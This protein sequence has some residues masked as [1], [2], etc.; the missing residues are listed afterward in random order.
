LNPTHRFPQRT[1]AL[2]IVLA[3]SITTVAWLVMRR[4]SPT[5]DP[6]G[7]G[8]DSFRPPG[9]SDRPHMELT[10]DHR[11]ARVQHKDADGLSPLEL[12]HTPQ[13]VITIRRTFS[14]A[15]ALLKEEASLNGQPVP[16]PRR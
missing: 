1:L 10:A 6:P 7:A 9:E 12:V 5:I 3:L 14:S 8:A 16:V 15:G 4:P 2:V 11:L 13:G